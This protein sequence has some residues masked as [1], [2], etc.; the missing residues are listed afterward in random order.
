[1]DSSVLNPDQISCSSVA[2]QA[3][4]TSRKLPNLDLK[5]PVDDK[6]ER[7][8]NLYTKYSASPTRCCRKIS[9]RSLPLVSPTAENHFIET[10]PSAEVE[11]ATDSPE[12]GLN[13]EYLDS[14]TS[15]KSSA[16]VSG[17]Y[18]RDMV[19][20]FDFPSQSFNGVHIKPVGSMSQES[21]KNI[22]KKCTDTL[23][24]TQNAC[25]TVCCEGPKTSSQRV[26]S[27]S[28]TVGNTG[29]VVH[30]S[31]S[32]KPTTAP[33]PKFCLKNKLDVADCEAESLGLG[34]TEPKAE[35]ASPCDPENGENSITGDTTSSSNS[36]LMP[37][38]SDAK[39]LQA[40]HCLSDC[41]VQEPC[42]AVMEADIVSCTKHLGE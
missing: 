29:K 24:S 3:S 41:D 11:G 15:R 5:C 42:T 25:L 7:R 19:E 26:R 17:A 30:H 6:P 34:L 38:H 1:M 36:V 21:F 33:K 13:S 22:A 37:I 12:L 18:I 31:R 10:S 16:P 39:Q 2:A 40:G 35:I 32:I 20:R 9:K 8:I 23:Q 4:K 28:E 14:P 27:Q